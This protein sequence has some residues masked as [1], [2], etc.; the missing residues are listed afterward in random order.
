MRKRVIRSRTMEERAQR[1]YLFGKMV[2]NRAEAEHIDGIST[3]IPRS[4]HR[5]TEKCE[6]KLMASWADQTLN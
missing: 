6:I 5:L 1:D 3:E 4:A 2:V